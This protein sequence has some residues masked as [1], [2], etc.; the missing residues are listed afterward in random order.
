MLRHERLPIS[1]GA[2]R[3]RTVCALDLRRRATLSILLTTL[4]LLPQVACSGTFDEPFPGGAGASGAPGTAGASAGATNGISGS[5]GAAG[6]GGVPSQGGAPPASGAG[7]SA[8]GSSAGGGAGA[9]NG[10]TSGGPPAAGAGGQDVFGTPPTC[11]SNQRW[12]GGDRGSPL[13]HPGGAC[14]ACHTAEREGP[15]F[16]IAGTL[17]PS[18]HEPNDCNGAGTSSGAIV[19]ITDA[20]NVE[21]RLPVNAAGNF[22]LEDTRVSLPYRAK[23]VA[24]GRERPMLTPQSVG[25]CNS[26]H[27]Q[28]GVN[29][30]PGRIVLP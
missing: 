2:R 11:T 18:A 3:A 21:H 17:Y 26:C 29:A 27:A 6:Q 24:S 28:T 10:G 16:T 12:T 14:I 8:A 19:V 5:S 9:P 7:A 30:A 20:Q 4:L 23:V 22:F 15:T 1:P 13:M 25:D